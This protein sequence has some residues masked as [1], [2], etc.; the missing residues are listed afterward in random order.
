MSNRMEKIYINNELKIRNASSRHSYLNL[1]LFFFI[2]DQ[3]MYK[4]IFAHLFG[5]IRV[6][7][8]TKDPDLQYLDSRTQNKI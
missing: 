5:I 8:R 2:F 3:I 4:G 7:F 1:F 6:S